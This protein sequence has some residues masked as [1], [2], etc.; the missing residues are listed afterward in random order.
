MDEPIADSKPYAT[1]VFNHEGEQYVM[2]QDYERLR[3][4]NNH[5]W[6]AISDMKAMA[7]SQPDMDRIADALQRVCNAQFA[8]RMYDAGWMTADEAKMFGV[9]PDENRP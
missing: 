3:A 1:F 2:R 5:L 8:R 6:R 9:Q 4:E 7:D